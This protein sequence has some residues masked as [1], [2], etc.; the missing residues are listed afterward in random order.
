MNTSFISKENVMF[1][2]IF[3][4]YSKKCDS[5]P[6]SDFRKHFAVLSETTGKGLYS[7]HD[8]NSCC[9]N[10]KYFHGNLKFISIVF[11][12]NTCVISL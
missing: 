10:K 12:S 7:F 6:L 8:L 11:K 5:L 9:T 2:L 1:L 4:K 3:L